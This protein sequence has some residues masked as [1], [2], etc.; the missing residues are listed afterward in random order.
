ME[1]VGRS[2]RFYRF[3]YNHLGDT[4]QKRVQFESMLARRGYR[5][6]AST[7]DTSDYLFNEAYERALT[8]RDNAMRRRV[9]QA[10]LDHTREQAVYFNDLS[11]RVL[12]YRPPEILVLHLNSINAATAG[13][14]L[15][16]FKDL[17]YRFVSLAEAQSDPAY[18]R[19]PAVATRFGPMWQYRWAR[20]RG[21]K[22]DGSLE[23]EPPQ[24]V[25]DYGAGK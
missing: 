9:E 18:Q 13:R 4:E 22:V 17:N 19:S 1:A 5:V 11:A 6:A 3:P 16:V 20:E 23:K 25:A 10:Y 15:K 2:L 12:G 8:Q 21:V 7:I 24:W 14:M